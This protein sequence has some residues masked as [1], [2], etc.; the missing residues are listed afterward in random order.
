M[1]LLTLIRAVEHPAP[2]TGQHGGRYNAPAT[3]SERRTPSSTPQITRNWS[4]CHG[5]PPGDP[6]RTGRPREQHSHASALSIFSLSAIHDEHTGRHSASAMG[7]KVAA[8]GSP[9]QYM[10]RDGLPKPAG[11]LVLWPWLR[12]RCGSLVCAARH[13]CYGSPFAA[14]LSNL[15]AWMAWRKGWA[16]VKCIPQVPEEISRTAVM[17]VCGTRFA[18]GRTEED[19]RRGRA[20]AIDGE[21][22]TVEHAEA[23]SWGPHER[24]T[25]PLAGPRGA[26]EEDRTGQS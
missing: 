6:W 10:R 23:D 20:H 8:E 19:H 3:N 5:D 13:W 26:K 9:M 25:E 4:P 21:D 18:R 16:V 15:V 22:V 17:F 11:L 2:G 14:A 7:Y 1:R 24:C 12:G